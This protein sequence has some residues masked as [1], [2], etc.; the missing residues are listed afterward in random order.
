MELTESILTDERFL[1]SLKII[2]IARA[3]SAAAMIITNMTIHLA[4]CTCGT[5]EIYKC[6]EANQIDVYS[7]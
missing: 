6:S 3:N 4:E 5:R 7:I 1:Y 2:A